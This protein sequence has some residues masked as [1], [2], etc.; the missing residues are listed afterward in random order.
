MSTFKGY[1]LLK[2]SVGKKIVVKGKVSTVIWQ[3][4]IGSIKD[5]PF[6]KY[7]DLEEDGFQTILYSKKNIEPNETLEITGTVI[8]IKGHSKRIDEIDEDNYSEY[9]ILVETFRDIE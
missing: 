9:H 4:I 5:Y 7:F 8:E 3:H 6:A 2:E 1:D